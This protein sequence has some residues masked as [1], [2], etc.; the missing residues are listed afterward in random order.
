[1]LQAKV[2]AGNI[3]DK[4]GLID[5]LQEK[6][7]PGICKIW[8]DTGY[9]GSD[10]K[11]IVQQQGADL[12][13]V[14]RPPGRMRIYNDQWKA[15]WIPIERSFS[16]LPRRWVVE[17]TFAWMGR[18]RRLHRDYEYLPNIS[19]TYLYVSMARLMLSRWSK[20]YA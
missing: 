6:K 12:E 13:V 15:E 2:T 19:E 18:N 8:A 9:Q 20:K 7:H 4:Q 3:S 14:K 10:L 5:I 16:V 17:R 11:A 1:M